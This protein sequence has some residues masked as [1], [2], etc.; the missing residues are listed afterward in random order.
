MRRWQYYVFIYKTLLGKL[1][2]YL[3]T[4]LLFTTSIYQM[5]SARWLILKVPKAV[6]ELGKSAFSYCAWE[7]WNSLQNTLHLYVLVPLSE[8]KLC[9]NVS[10]RPDQ[11]LMMCCLYCMF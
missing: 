11:L 5:L 6:T 2:L 3:G 4:L 1:P 10:C 8:F 9:V 7:E